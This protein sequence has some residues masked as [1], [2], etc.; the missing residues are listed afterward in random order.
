MRQ[1][2][3]GVF[4]AWL[5]SKYIRQSLQ[6]RFYDVI[7]RTITGRQHNNKTKCLTVPIVMMKALCDAS[8]S[9]S[10]KNVYYMRNNS[11]SQLSYRVIK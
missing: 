4:T 1:L 9:N 11:F 3:D 10:R 6:C 2:Y 8:A 5:E 7:G